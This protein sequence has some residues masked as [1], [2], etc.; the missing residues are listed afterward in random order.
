MVTYETSAGA[1]RRPRRTHYIPDVCAQLGV[2]CI[3]L[4]E[5]MRREG[6]SF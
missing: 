2:A 5:V 3:D 6:L 4:L 1:K